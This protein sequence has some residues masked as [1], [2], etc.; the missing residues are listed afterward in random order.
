M[1][2]NDDEFKALIRECL[3]LDPYDIVKAGLDN[4]DAYAYFKWPTELEGRLVEMLCHGGSANGAWDEFLEEYL[5]NLSRGG[6]KWAKAEALM[7]FG[8]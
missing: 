1:N 6:V 4:F 8:Q 5:E 2:K 3:A 7:R